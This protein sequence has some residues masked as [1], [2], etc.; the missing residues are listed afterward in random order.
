MP[1]PGLLLAIALVLSFSACTT[2]GSMPVDPGKPA[3]ETASAFTLPADQGRFFNG[4]GNCAICH[5]KMTDEAGTDV[6][7][8]TLW[9]ATML[10]NAARDPYW[11]AT[12]RSEMVLA[13]EL[14]E[15]IQKKCATCHMPMAEFSAVSDGQEPNILD[16]GFASEKNTYHGL[17][18]D[19]VS[20]SLCHQIQPEN[21]DQPASFSGGFLVDSAVP[22]GKRSAYGPF[23][24]EANL[25][26]VMQGVS[27]FLPVESSHL[28]D[29]AMCGTCHDLHTPYLDDSGQVAGEFPEQMIYSEW[30][31]ITGQEKTCQSCHMPLAEGGVQ[32][33]TT[34]GAKRSPFFQHIFVGGNAYM[35]RVFAQNA[36]TLGAASS[37]AQFE[38]IAA[39]A[40]RQIEQDTAVLAIDNAAVA[41]DRLGAQISIQSKVGHKFP[42]GFPSRRA[43]LHIQVADSAGQLVFESGGCSPDGEITANDNDA[44][45]LR[46]EPH[47]TQITAP[48]QVQIYEAIMLD[49]SGAVTTTLLRGA[50]YAKDNRLLPAGFDVSA[51]SADIAAYGAGEDA[52]FAPGGD[53][54]DLDIPLEGAAGPY[55]LTV[56]LLYQ[57]I[58]YRW[59]AN[60]AGQDSPEARTFLAVSASV[61]NTPLVAAST[62]VEI[63]P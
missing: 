36:E 22:K 55:T 28:A 47:Y 59:A 34:G 27:G 51:A 10:G 46:F 31:N 41:D 26:V 25:S 17:A 14:S 57:T 16:D 40:Q 61:P 39:H 8:D 37:P 6:S 21:F 33:S 12:V 11:L 3:A 44:D 45:A 9:S 19:G 32:L 49:S 29:S 63:A 15:T 2:P 30:A 4:S 52:D 58:G 48:D 54:I 38:T 35:T 1:K 13:P 60:I 56:E 62:Q 18:V 43:W 7:T 50:S 20:C 24:T 53:M 23:P 42:A 5:T